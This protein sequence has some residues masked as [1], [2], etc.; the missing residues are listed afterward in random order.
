MRL[1]SFDIAHFRRLL[2]DMPDARDY[3]YALLE[4]RA[5]ENSSTDRT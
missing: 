4:A 3:I 2:E 1:L 5:A